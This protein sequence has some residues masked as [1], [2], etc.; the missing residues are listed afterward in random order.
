M[1]DIHFCRTE[2]L[3][4]CVAGADD[5]PASFKDDMPSG[6]DLP[7]WHQ[8]GHWGTLAA[9]S[10]MMWH[11]H[12]KP[13]MW[14]VSKVLQAVYWNQ[15]KMAVTNSLISSC[16]IKESI[17]MWSK[18]R[19]VLNATWWEVL[20]LSSMLF[21]HLWIVKERKPSRAGC[22]HWLAIC[23]RLLLWCSSFG[24]GSGN[25]L[26]MGYTDYYNGSLPV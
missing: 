2:W 23:R 9:G 3:M 21:S 5:I 25:S 13:L 8:G 16:C 14:T 20:A 12:C 24:I 7:K 1:D 22:L 18:F 6:V 4:G 19:R 15:E 17:H 26:Q 11:I 10:Q